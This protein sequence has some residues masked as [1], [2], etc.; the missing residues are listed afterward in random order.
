[1][2]KPHCIYPGHPVTIARIIMIVFPSLEAALAA[3]TKDDES[4]AAL[5]SLAVPGAAWAVN[6][7]LT[8]L[9]SLN[10]GMQ[11]EEAIRLA[12][13][14]WAVYDGQGASPNPQ[15]YQRFMNGQE[16][17]NDLKAAVIENFQK[18]GK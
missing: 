13:Q 12:D 14:E 7:A 17:A 4:P 6:N 16:Q 9:R 5:R 3:K 10:E 11:P 15:M 2:N 1:M 18:W 8:L